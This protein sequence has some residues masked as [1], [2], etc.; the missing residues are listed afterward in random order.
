[1][2]KNRLLTPG[3]IYAIHNR[4]AAIH[5]V[6]YGMF[7]EEENARSTGEYYKVFLIDGKILKLVDWAFKYEE[8]PA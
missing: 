8:V 7:L 1:M 2:K 6:R 3:N 5:R 4:S